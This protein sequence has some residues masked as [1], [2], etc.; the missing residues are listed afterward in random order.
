M[1]KL[2]HRVD[3]RLDVRSGEIGTVGAVGYGGGDEWQTICVR[4]LP[5][6]NG[7]GIKGYLEDVR[8]FTI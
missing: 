1:D 2:E 8:R 3:N 7:E 4:V 6:F 5:L